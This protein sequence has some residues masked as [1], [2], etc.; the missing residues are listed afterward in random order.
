MKL[1]EK[2]LTRHDLYDGRVLKMHVDDI[3]LPDGKT[4]QRECVD[5]P[6]GVC[7]GALT[8]DNELMFV[9]Q[10]RYPYHEVVLE[11]PAGKLEQGEN[12]DDAIRREL[13]E[14]TGCTGRDWRFL[15]NMYPTPGYT[16]ELLRLYFCR[17]D[18]DTDELSLDEDEFIE[19]T[20]IPLDKAVRMVMS[21]E[22]PDGKTQIIILKIK[23]L[24]GGES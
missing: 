12:P 13:K 4:A 20:R 9:S 15:G 6:G 22:I 21:N 11:L 3:E 23:E 7:V 18:A 24:L 10:Y 19:V 5:H 17:V 1:N 16:N 2:T 14:E 8:E